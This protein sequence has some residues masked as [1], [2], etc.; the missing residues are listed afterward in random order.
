MKKIFTSVTL[1]AVTAL[2]ATSC[3]STDSQANATDASPTVLATVSDPVDQAVHRARTLAASYDYEAALEKLTGIS[4]EAVEEARR[5]ITAQKDAA[6]LWVDN[7]KISHL[8]VHSLIVDTDRAFDQDHRAA[9]YADYMVTIKEFRAI[10]KQLHEKN[11]VLVNPDDVASTDAD[12]RMS[13]KPIYLPAGK[14]PLVLSQDDV[15]YYEYMQH[16]GFASNL[17]ID[18]KGTIVNTYYDAQGKKHLGEYDVAPIVD[19]FVKEHPDFSYRGSKGILAVTGYNGVLGY[20]T[21]PIAYPDA[22]NIEDETHKARAVAEALKADGWVFASHSWGHP[23]Y[24]KITPAALAEDNR[25]W[26]TEV[27]PIVGK[28]PHLIYPFG[29]DISGVEPYAGAKYATLQASGFRSFYNVDASTPAWAQLTPGYY[30]QARINLDGI[31]FGYA[32]K[33]REHLLDQ[34]FDVGSVLDPARPRE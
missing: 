2:V 10:L 32:L 8:F 31:R 18:E 22:K 17:T 7:S 1:L 16:D 30:R 6:V 27:E 15:N 12:G 11:Y 9:G 24:G 14:T 3:T 28:T 23:A 33:G 26:V 19:S 21:S 4:G 25:K 5:E 29:S 13:Y 20:K 34:F